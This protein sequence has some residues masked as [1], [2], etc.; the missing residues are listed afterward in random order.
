MTI[1]FHFS[2]C[3]NYRE[4][5]GLVHP[6]LHFG[7]LL[8]WALGSDPSCQNQ[9]YLVVEFEDKPH[10][11]HGVHV[12]ALVGDGRRRSLLGLGLSRSAQGKLGF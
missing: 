4:L 1:H 2:L 6:D 8:G 7:V 10:Y 5:P 12:Q 9:S 3:L 11:C